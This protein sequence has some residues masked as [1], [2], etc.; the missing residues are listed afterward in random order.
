MTTCIERLDIAD[1]AID[2]AWSRME[3]SWLC[4]SCDPPLVVHSKSLVGFLV[5][6]DS[7][8]FNLTRRLAIPTAMQSR[9]ISS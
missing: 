8:V 4:K 7:D 6:P 9:W 3:R 2:E 5:S 1:K